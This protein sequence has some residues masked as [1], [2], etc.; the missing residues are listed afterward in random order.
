MGNNRLHPWFLML[1]GLPGSGKS[2]FAS[3][4]QVYGWTVHS[5]DEIRAEILG[6]ENDQSKQK[7]VFD[8]LH[9]RVFS[10]LLSGKDVCYDATNLSYKRRAQFIRDLDRVVTNTYKVC[11]MAATPYSECLRRNARRKRVV[12]EEVIERMYRSFDPPMYAEGWDEIGI[13][14]CGR[15]DALRLISIMSSV[16]HD[17][18][19]HKLTIGQHCMLAYTYAMEHFKCTQFS[20]LAQAALLHDIGKPFTK[21]FTNNRGERTEIAHYY[22]HE[23]ISAYD[24]YQYSIGTNDDRTE[25]ATLIRWHMHP[26]TVKRSDNPKKTENKIR[27]LLGEEMYKKIELLHEADEAAH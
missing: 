15:E 24:S 8:E 17:N 11:I 5:S 25:I 10:D 4:L 2:T 26:Y 7:D 22:G 9:R 16:E 27:N 18:P 6:D 14:D 19:H 13:F 20:T 3:Q 12:P 1:V 21:S 23:H